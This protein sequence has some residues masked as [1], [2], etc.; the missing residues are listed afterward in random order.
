MGAMKELLENI[1]ADVRGECE[2][3]GA[4]CEVVEIGRRWCRKCW[5]TFQV[6]YETIQM[7]VEMCH[8]CS[9][10]IGSEYALGRYWCKDCL[11]VFSHE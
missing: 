4:V 8:F 7:K 10:K 9:K 6:E 1:E 2:D 11:R 3:C 5:H